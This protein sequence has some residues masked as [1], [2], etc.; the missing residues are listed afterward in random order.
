MSN[1]QPAPFLASGSSIREGA[2]DLQCPTCGFMFTHF[3]KS[4]PSESEDS[5]LVLTFDGE[6][7][8]TFEI[9]FNEYKGCVFVEHRDITDPWRITDDLIAANETAEDVLRDPTLNLIAE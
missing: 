9:A 6:C 7:G 3:M 8:H 4:R 5:G 2:F 1:Q